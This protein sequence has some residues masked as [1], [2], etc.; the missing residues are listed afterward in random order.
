MIN[1]FINQIKMVFASPEKR[2]VIQTHMLADETINVFNDLTDIIK[3][4]EY[5]I[6]DHVKVTQDR[7]HFLR[8]NIDTQV[9]QNVNR[10]TDTK[11]AMWI[12]TGVMLIGTLFSVKGLQ[13]FFGEFYASVSLWVIIPIAIA[14]AA[15]LVI[16]SICL[17]HFSEQYRMKNMV[18]FIH[19]KIAA[20]VIVLFLPIVNL[21]EGF[22][23]N[24][25]ESVMAMNILAV[26]IDITAHTAL[27]SMHNVFVTA[28]NSK[29]A[30][31]A[32][33]N[34]DNNQDKADKNLRAVNYLF[35]K[36]KNLFSKK[37]T[38]FVYNY[39]RLESTN[40]E[41]AR[42]IMFMLSNFLIWMI[43][44]KVVQH[45]V[46]NYHAN[47]NGQPVVEL[48]YFTPENDAVRKGWDQLS[49]VT[50]YDTLPQVQEQP[51]PIIENRNEPQNFEQ[52]INQDIPPNYTE[53]M[54][55]IQFNPN[56]KIL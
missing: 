49:K 13:F 8:D 12:L 16:G 7:E 6:Q 9:D 53:V 38:N 26:I 4:G 22:N 40:A 29:I 39:K 36:A 30:I 37:A 23:S 44:N 18:V 17:N 55:N 25:S 14:L 48:T 19:A 52:T 27:V 51:E 43:N 28:E 46:L 54:D 3:K 32:L 47:E 20:Y 35:I 45:A 42:H 34:K 31:K 50:G 2:L 41:A 15:V 33:K 1:N 11:R 24:Y 56:D 21:I 5:V 10:N